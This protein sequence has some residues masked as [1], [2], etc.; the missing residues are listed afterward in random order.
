MS[1]AGS[2][3]PQGESWITAK[4]AR[5]ERAL[6]YV[7][8]SVAAIATKERIDLAKMNPQQKYRLNRRITQLAQAIESLMK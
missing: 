8:Q 1:G 3:T 7:R 2:I 6:S 5:Q 4:Q